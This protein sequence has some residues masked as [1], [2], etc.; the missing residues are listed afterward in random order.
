MSCFP[1]LFFSHSGRVSLRCVSHPNGRNLNPRGRKFARE[2]VP[3]ML[4]A[5]MSVIVAGV[6]FVPQLPGQAADGPHPTDGTAPL[7]P[8]SPG[9]MARRPEPQVSLETLRPSRRPPARSLCFADTTVHSRSQPVRT[10]FRP[11]L[12]IPRRNSP[13][14]TNRCF[15]PKLSSPPHPTSLRTAAR[16]SRPLDSAQSQ[17][18]LLAQPP[19]V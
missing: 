5:L 9:Q 7:K 19:P 13:R 18:Y 14:I 15:T 4:L 6:S 8:P 1:R 11:T 2:R 17:A 10:P 12:P 16:S 3:R